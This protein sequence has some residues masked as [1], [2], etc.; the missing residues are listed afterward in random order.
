VIIKTVTLKALEI[1]ESSN[2]QYEN[3]FHE[4]FSYELHSKQHVKICDLD[5][6]I[7]YNTLCHEKFVAP[8]YQTYYGNVFKISTTAWKSIYEQKIV[9]IKDK[10]I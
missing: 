6:E 1:Y 5:S 7:I 10:T 4:N 3:V 2:I 9:F 8:L